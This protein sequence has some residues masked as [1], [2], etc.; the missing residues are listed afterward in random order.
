MLQR[1]QRNQ[2]HY[3]PPDEPGQKTERT[4]PNRFV[5]GELCLDLL[6]QRHGHELVAHL[7]AERTRKDGLFRLKHTRGGGK[8]ML[9]LHFDGSFPGSFPFSLFSLFQ[10]LGNACVEGRASARGPQRWRTTIVWVMW[11][12][13]GGAGAIY[14]YDSHVRRL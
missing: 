13:G 8:H 2:P 5:P 10:C 1:V 3:H 12:G 9:V 7:A 11:V 14:F 4:K 6:S